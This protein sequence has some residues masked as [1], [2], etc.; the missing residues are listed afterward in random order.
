MV[1]ARLRKVPEGHLSLTAQTRTPK[2]SGVDHRLIKALSH[3]LRERILGRLNVGVA[4]PNQLAQ[5]FGEGL[6]QVSYHV[7]VLKE[8]GCIE[9]VRTEPRRGAVEH[10]YRGI[11]RAYFHTDDWRQLPP[12]LQASISSNVLQVLIS[13][14]AQAAEAETFDKREDRHLSWTPVV[15]DEEGWTG[16]CSLLNE[17]LERVLDIQAESAGRLAESGEKGIPAA[18]ALMNFETPSPEWKQAAK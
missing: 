6:S 12:S 11:R 13:E 18:V 17:M 1:L 16:I 8:Y 7:K 15:V 10:F 4:S 3:P 9:L 14:I 5:E 2:H